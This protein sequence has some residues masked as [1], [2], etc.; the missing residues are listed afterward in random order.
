MIAFALVIAGCKETKK[1]ETPLP[2]QHEQHEDS[3]K[4]SDLTNS[5]TEKIALDGDKKWI[6]NKETNRGVIAMLSLIKSD[7]SN[8]INEYKKLGAALNKE[9]NTIIKECTMK[10]LSHD[11]LH[12]FLMPLI[13]K[14]EL[15]QSTEDLEIDNT[16]KVSLKKHLELY[17]TYFE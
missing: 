10:G 16:L 3:Q 17:H 1:T 4:S 2:E 9:K 6:A 14:I 12:V 15:L 7:K 8:T 13:D 5:W 11:N